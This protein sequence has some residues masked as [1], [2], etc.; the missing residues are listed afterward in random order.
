MI[1]VE[2]VA[3]AVAEV[4]WGVLDDGEA[5]AAVALAVAAEPSSCPGGAKS[6]QGRVRAMKGRAARILTGMTCGE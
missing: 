3:A 6:T 5:V 2:T 1:D 4:A